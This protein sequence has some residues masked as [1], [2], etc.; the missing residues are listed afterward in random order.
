MEYW[1]VLNQAFVLQGYG[2]LYEVLL[3]VPPRYHGSYVLGTRAGV[4]LDAR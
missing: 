3:V 1:Y 2:F 4:A